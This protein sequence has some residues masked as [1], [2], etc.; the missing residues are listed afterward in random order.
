[1]AKAEN[2]SNDQKRRFLQE[3]EKI[4][5]G[6][7]GFGKIRLVIYVKSGPELSASIT[8]PR[9]LLQI[10]ITGTWTLDQNRKD[11]AKNNHR[12]RH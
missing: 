8:R 11:H 10:P 5:V 9:Y 3:N 7:C 6:D 2:T 4:S 12:H 1:M